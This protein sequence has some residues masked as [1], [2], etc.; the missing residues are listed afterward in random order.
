MKIA[1]RNIVI[2]GGASGLGFAFGE[3]LYR[4]QARVWSLDR[5]QHS[6]AAA[7]AARETNGSHRGKLEFLCC[8]VGDEAQVIE[9]VARI[10]SDSGG[11]DVLIN[12]AAVLRDQSLVSRLR[13][14][15]KQHSLED[16]NETLRSNLTGPFLMTREVAS[17]MISAKRPGIVVNISSISRAGNAGQSAYS[18][19]KA[20]IDALT[21]TWAQELAVYGIRVVGLAP[22]FV[23][24]P[25]TQRIPALF[26]EGI[27]QKSPLKR[28][29]TLGEFGHTIQYIIENDYLHG[30]V[31]EL[32]GGLRF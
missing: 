6:I 28:F 31:L 3:Q 12:N 25:M 22:G 9:T 20:G 29:G 1:G 13:K 24:T 19:S 16:W 15:I 4:L 23:E 8:D 7:M 14:K 10:E 21:A 32:D 26:L 18:A 5:N 2:T 27:R 30:K 11:I 17:V